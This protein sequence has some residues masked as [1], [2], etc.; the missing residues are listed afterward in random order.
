MS[1]LVL[2]VLGA[3][4]PAP[5][6]TDEI[7][8][9]ADLL[10]RSSVA[11]VWPA[12]VSGRDE[13]WPL[14]PVWPALR[15][16]IAA[17]MPVSEALR[18]KIEEICGV[19]LRA[20]T[21]VTLIADLDPKERVIAL[22]VRGVKPRPLPEL[23]P[24]GLEVRSVESTPVLFFTDHDLGVASLGD[25]ILIGSSRGMSRQLLHE[26]APRGANAQDKLP[27][28]A[29]RLRADAPW[30]LAM[31]ISDKRRREIVRAAGP[32]VGPVLA[33]VRG[34]VAT[35]DARALTVSVDADSKKGAT[36]ALHALRA[37]GAGWQASGRVIYGATE[38][39][40][41]L[42]STGARLPLVP[43]ELSG[44]K[45]DALGAW[46]ADLKIEL[47]ASIRPGNRVEARY[48]VSDGKAYLVAALALA[49]AW[50]PTSKD[51]NRVEA[52]RLLFVLRELE[53]AHKKAHGKHLAC[54]PTPG[55]VP[56]LPVAWPPDTCFAPLGFRPEEP[57]RFQLSAGVGDD[58]L[59]LVA[60]SD[61]D[62]DGVPEVYY[63]DDDALAVRSFG[64][65]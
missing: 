39:G 13:L 12:L 60:R 11:E 34:V 51:A 44:D 65:H 32:L 61:I 59:T 22:V 15:A 40:R 35:G 16:E 24:A 50:R 62:N 42:G 29:A 47:T 58:R 48:V 43:S 21:K 2:L 56:R 63:L 7:P 25:H 20:A 49:G 52:E 18:A 36:A 4:A 54:P 10:V 3:L 46:L 8:P 1:T 37:I 6:L 5:S 23:A 31:V 14:V 64:T 53:R 55:E 38:W 41:A 33:V 57:L 26:R 30:Q 17:I 28:L 45:L 9:D 27:L 19:D